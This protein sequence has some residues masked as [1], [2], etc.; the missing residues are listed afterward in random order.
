MYPLPPPEPLPSRARLIAIL[1][2][3]LAA[4]LQIEAA[5]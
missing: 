2:A 1:L 4:K 3:A 5:E